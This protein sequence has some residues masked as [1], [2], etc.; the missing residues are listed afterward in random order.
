MVLVTHHLDEVPPR[1]T[2]A[3]LLRSGRVLL[4]GAFDDV[5]TSGNLSDCFGMGLHVERRANGRLSAY[6]T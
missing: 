1:M 6:S 3:L 4:S 2:H 5:I